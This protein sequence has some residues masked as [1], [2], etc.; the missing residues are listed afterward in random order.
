MI[1]IKL[2]Q[3]MDDVHFD[4]GCRLSIADIA[5][6]TELSRSTLNRIINTKGYNV[7]LDAIDQ[8]CGF[9]DCQPGDLLEYYP[10]SKK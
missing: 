3:K 8:L 2:K 6:D 10:D 9:F 4:T 1:R 5:K 7:G